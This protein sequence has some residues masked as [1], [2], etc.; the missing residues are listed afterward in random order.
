MQEDTF[1]PKTTDAIQKLIVTFSTLT[2]VKLFFYSTINKMIINSHQMLS[3]SQGIYNYL[4]HVNFKKVTVFP[5]ILDNALSGFFILN[6]SSTLKEQVMMYRSFLDSTSDRLEQGSFHRLMVLD[7]LDPNQLQNY[8]GDLSLISNSANSSTNQK[9]AHHKL[10]IVNKHDKGKVINV[11]K[12]F[13]NALKYINANISKPLT[14]EDIAQRVYLSPSYLS[15]LFKNYFNVNF[16]D[17]INV[18]KVA[19]AQ[20]RLALSAAPINELSHRL[21]FSQASYF[22]KIFKQKCGLTPSK[23]RMRSKKIKKIYTISR[24]LSW[25]KDPSVYAVSQKFFADKRIDFKAQELNG[26]TYVYAIGDL[27]SDEDNGWIYTVNCM[28]PTMSPA[29]V[30]VGDKS[31][32]QWI[33]TGVENF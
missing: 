2:N 15:R 10:H 23:Y 9:D 12:N 19:L 5:V 6:V 1:L 27:N 32:I 18:R 4:T 33:Y 29:G 17:Y 11:D 7:A 30:S 31:V 25:L 8:M 16:I 14:L 24:D 20:D 22:T 13:V 26:S 21:G 28:Q 3:S